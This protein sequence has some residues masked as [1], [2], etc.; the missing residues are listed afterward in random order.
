MEKALNAGMLGPFEDQRKYNGSS[1]QKLGKQLDLDAFFSF[2]YQYLAETLADEDRGCMELAEK[3]HHAFILE[4]IQ[5]RDGN[6]LAASSAGLMQTAVDMRA[7][8]HMSWTEFYELFQFHY[9][10]KEAEGGL[11][12]VKAFK[13]YFEDHWSNMIT[14]RAVGQH[15]RCDTCAELTKLRREHPDKRERQ[16]AAQAFKAHLNRMFDDRR[17]DARLT[18]LS[19]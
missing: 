7:M 11:A 2:V 1:D 3:G 5:A 6:P 18:H 12:G 8:P 15:D 19:E 16:L 17:M 4:W 9:M 14:F 10:E 13:K